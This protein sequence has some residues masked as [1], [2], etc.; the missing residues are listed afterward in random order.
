[1]EYTKSLDKLI[2][3][4]RSLPGIGPR[5]AERLAFHILKSSDSNA[6]D[7]MQAIDDVKLN[8]KNCEVCGN[9]TEEDICDI[10]KD[11][12]R[13]REIICIVEEISEIFAIERSRE[14]RGLFHV[15]G[16]AISPLSG[17]YP[18][19]LN[20]QRLEERLENSQVKEVILA[21]N[22]NVE[23]E[24]TALYL[25]KILKKYNVKIT[26]IANGVPIGSDLEYVDS[27]TLSKAIE[28]RKEI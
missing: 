1:M 5:M 18:E 13:N 4:L 9:L 24:A 3:I 7:F 20:I 27:L 6:K 19:D 15:L 16:G 22:P 21:T 12:L 2:T 14:F 25:A 8:I 11:E 23:G 28:G 26:R 10:C 17:I